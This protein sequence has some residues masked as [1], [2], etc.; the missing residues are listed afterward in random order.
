MLDL[1][2]SLVGSG[3]A[4]LKIMTPVLEKFSEFGKIP[5]QKVCYSRGRM[6]VLNGI[7]YWKL[8]CMR[9]FLYHQQLLSYFYLNVTWQVLSC[10]FHSLT[11]P[12]S[13][14]WIRKLKFNGNNIFVKSNVYR[15]CHQ[16]NP[17]NPNISKGI[18]HTVLYT[19]LEVQTRRTCVT[20]NSFFCCW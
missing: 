12:S 3:W 6:I 15:N 10:N 9:D 18:L 7:L 11:D 16:F 4:I 17:L 13:E 20:I 19:F 14:L 8:P 5:P 2:Q 1:S